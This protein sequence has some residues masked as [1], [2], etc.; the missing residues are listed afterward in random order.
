MTGVQKSS[1]SPRKKAELHPFLTATAR[2]IPEGNDHLTRSPETDLQREGEE[3]NQPALLVNSLSNHGGLGAQRLTK[4]MLSQVLA[5]SRHLPQSTLQTCYWDFCLMTMV[6]PTQR[7]I[8]KADKI[9]QIPQ[10]EL[11]QA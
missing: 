11:F 10:E 2:T 1:R 7:D 5:T 3:R 9:P 8:S 6:W 4:V